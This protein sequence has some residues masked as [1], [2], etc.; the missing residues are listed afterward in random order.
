M[1]KRRSTR[2]AIRCSNCIHFSNRHFILNISIFLETYLE[3]SRTS[4]IKVFCGN[5]GKSLTIFAKR[6]HHDRL[7][8]D[9]SALLQDKVKSISKKCQ[10]I[11]SMQASPKGLAKSLGTLSSAT[12]GILLSSF[13][14]R[15]LQRKQTQTL[16]LNRDYNS[17][18][19]LDPL[20][21]EELDCWILQLRLSDERSVISQELEL[22]I[23]AVA[24][25]TGWGAFLSED[26]NRRSMI[27]S[28]KSAAY[29]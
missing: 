12:L 4:M 23:Q 18:I 6:L 17:K 20:C 5:G 8:G 14:M 10:D 24:S 28:R 2:T 26:I 11:L 15:Y 9:V 19:T 22:L 7:G 29:K 25:K 1:K 21:E 3:P 27:S 13:Y 16:C